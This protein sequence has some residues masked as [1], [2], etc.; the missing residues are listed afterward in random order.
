MKFPLPTGVS[1]PPQIIP[2]YKSAKRYLKK[3]NKHNHKQRNFCS[4]TKE[5]KRNEREHTFHTSMDRSTNGKSIRQLL[6]LILLVGLCLNDC[7]TLPGRS[8]LQSLLLS[9]CF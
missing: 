1:A 7:T 2:A 4:L 9:C 5:K 8:D 3:Q 6:M